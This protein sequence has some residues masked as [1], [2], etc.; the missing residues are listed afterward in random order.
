VTLDTANENLNQL[1]RT[2]SMM[3]YRTLSMILKIS[4]PMYMVKG[5]LDLFLAQP[6]GS[7]SL[8]QR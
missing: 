7:K 8:F 3:P 5:V 1:R 2:H 4:N 6:F